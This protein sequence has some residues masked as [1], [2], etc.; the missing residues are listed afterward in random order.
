MPTVIKIL[1]CFLIIP[2]NVYSKDKKEVLPASSKLFSFISV[3][4]YS[5]E[6]AEVYNVKAEIICKT[7]IN[8]FVV[9]SNK[10]SESELMAAVELFK[11]ESIRS[12]D[13]K[14][15]E[16]LESVSLFIKNKSYPLCTQNIEAKKMKNF[17]AKACG[18]TY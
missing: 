13:I 7:E 16:R 12:G 6:K 14:N 4:R 15:C 8:P 3:N 18:R 1:L 17:L 5:T 10:I 9:V 11:T 2:I